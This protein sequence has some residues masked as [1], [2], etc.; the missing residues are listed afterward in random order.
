[1]P[2]ARLSENFGQQIIVDNRPCANTFIRSETTKWSK[3]IKD[4]GL[5]IE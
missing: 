2:T 1:L 5:K 3:I 4:I